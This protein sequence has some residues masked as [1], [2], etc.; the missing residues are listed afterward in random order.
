MNDCIRGIAATPDNGKFI[1]RLETPA[2]AIR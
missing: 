2:V 1:I